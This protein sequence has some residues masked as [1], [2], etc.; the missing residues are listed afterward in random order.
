MCNYII[1]MYNDIRCK[2]PKMLWEKIHYWNRS[3]F[4]L[5]FYERKKKT[6]QIMKPFLKAEEFFLTVNIPIVKHCPLTGETRI[7]AVRVGNWREICT[8]TG[9]SE[10]FFFFFF[11]DS[12]SEHQAL[13]FSCM[14]FFFL[15][16]SKTANFA[17]IF[18]YT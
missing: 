13:L 14:T 2:Y 10:V 1:T 17:N 7:N 11:P 12:L 5:C 16:C 3:I 8:Y 9:T 18:K 4:L 6:G 15:I